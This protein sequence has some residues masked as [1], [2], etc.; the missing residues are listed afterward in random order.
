MIAISEWLPPLAASLA[1]LALGL[2]KV[3]GWPTGGIRWR[4]KARGLPTSGTLSR[5]E[6]RVQ[7]RL[8]DLPA[9][10]RTSE[11]RIVLLRTVE[12]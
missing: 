4:R 10:H 5:L 11:S 9:L 7:L 8:C 12:T 6:Q 3:Y 2:R 1:F